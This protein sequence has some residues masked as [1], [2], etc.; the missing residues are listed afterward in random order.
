MIISNTDKNA[1]IIDDSSIMLSS[2]RKMCIDLGFKDENIVLEK[3]PRAAVEKCSHTQFSLIICDYNFNTRLN[4]HLN[5]RLNGRTIYDE[6]KFKKVLSH[7]AAFI[8][9]TGEGTSKIVMSI[10]ELNPDEYYLKPFNAQFFINRTKV[11]IKRRKALSQL[12]EMLETENYANFDNTCNEIEFAYPEFYYQIQKLKGQLYSKQSLHEEALKVYNSVLALKKVEWAMIGSADSLLEL[13]DYEASNDIIKELLARPIKSSDVM[14]LA[15]KYDIFSTDVPT[16][17]EHLSMANEIAP[18]NPDREFVIALLCISQ[19]DFR[20]AASRFTQ[21]YELSLDT[22][23]YSNN[24]RYYY[25]SC[26]LLELDLMSKQVFFN[27]NHDYREHMIFEQSM[28]NLEN[29]VL[30]KFSVLVN[31]GSYNYHLPDTDVEKTNS[32]YGDLITIHISIRDMKLDDAIGLLRNT[33]NKFNFCNIEETFHLI[34]LLDLL[35]FHKEFIIVRDKVLESL[36]ENN[37]I[38]DRA[39]LEI[40]KN[41]SEMHIYKI[42]KTESLLESFNE[43]FNSGHYIQLMEDLFKL[44]NINFHNKKVN[45]YIIKTLQHCWPKDFGKDKVYKLIQHCYSI[46]DK[47]MTKDEIEKTNLLE[48]YDNAI[49]LSE[50]MK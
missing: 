43:R 48:I 19:Q 50:K 20:N 14:S 1:L 22:Y 27:D 7:D 23:R 11:T 47:L 6:L 33:Y 35:S 3:F 32:Y 34:Y 13:G 4:T 40:I 28:H 16:A 8:I 41:I 31:D 36:K 37:S 15:A 10:L 38:L 26:C 46:C 12:Y 17:I 30:S 49:Q 2:L 5:T 29:E 24:P 45:Y 42:T 21:Y 44:K 39:R 25:L 9:I 18:G